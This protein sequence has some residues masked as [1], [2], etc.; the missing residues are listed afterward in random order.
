ME[1]NEDNISV[2][3]SHLTVC[4]LRQVFDTNHQYLQTLIDFCLFVYYRITYVKQ[5]I[6]DRKFC[7]SDNP[8]LHYLFTTNHRLSD[9]VMKFLLNVVATEN[10]SPLDLSTFVPFV[11]EV[12]EGL[13]TGTLIL[14]PRESH[15][16]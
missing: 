3:K 12:S 10:S 6:C 2:I 13:L 9:L 5:K 15:F 1:W 4:E 11:C 14:K 8:F 16:I 7:T